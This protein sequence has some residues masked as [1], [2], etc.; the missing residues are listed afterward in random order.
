MSKTDITAAPIHL[1]VW[2]EDNQIVT[3]YTFLK[4][5]SVPWR[6]SAGCPEYWQGLN[7]EWWQGISYLLDSGEGYWKFLSKMEKGFQF[8]SWNIKMA[9]GKEWTGVS[10]LCYKRYGDL[11]EATAWTCNRGDEG[12]DPERGREGLGETRGNRYRIEGVWIGNNKGSQPN[13]RNLHDKEMMPKEQEL[14][15]RAIM[16]FSV[17]EPINHEQWGTESEVLA[18]SRVR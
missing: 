12:I 3:K 1:P 14:E 13:L 2:W 4:M 9:T 7:A 15:F 11:Q 17:S 6:K 5:W 10:T 18:T 8:Y 16:E